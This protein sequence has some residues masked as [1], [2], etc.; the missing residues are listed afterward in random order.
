VFAEFPTEAQACAVLARMPAGMRGFV[1]AGLERH[2]LAAFVEDGA[3][4]GGN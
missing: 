2:P 3:G 1:A 4:G